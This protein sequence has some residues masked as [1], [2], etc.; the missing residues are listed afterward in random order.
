M[1]KIAPTLQQKRFPALAKASPIRLLR[2]AEP[3]C[4]K[5]QVAGPS[6]SETPVP[7]KARS[8]A[9][10]QEQERSTKGGLW[11]PCSSRAHAKW[12]RSTPTPTSLENTSGRQKRRRGHVILG[13]FRILKLRIQ[14]RIT[15]SAVVICPRKTNL[16]GM[17]PRPRRDKSSP[18]CSTG[19]DTQHW[20]RDR[21]GLSCL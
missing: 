4:K 7:G 13:N 11:P 15:L 19:A 2:L 10:E 14:V 3:N 5:Q 16:Y 17:N 8:K 9:K 6:G 1:F 18:L 12:P 20:C 21:F